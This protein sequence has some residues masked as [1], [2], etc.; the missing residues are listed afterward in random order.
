MNRQQPL[1][2]APP[3]GSANWSERSLLDGLTRRAL[4]SIN[5]AFLDLATDLAEEGRLKLISGLPPRAV[6]ALID[7]DAGQRLCERLPYTLFDLRFGDGGFWESEIAA[8]GGVQ[9]SDPVPATDDRLVA[10]ARAAIM[11]AWHLTQTRAAGARLVFGTSPATIAALATL[12]LATME[13]LARRVAPALT[14]RFGTRTRFWLQFEGCAVRPDEQSVDMLRQLGLQI[15][16]AE[17]ARSQA[18]QRRT[19][20]GIAA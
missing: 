4:C 19:R 10:F 2:L 13:R 20:R 3:A 8:A 11:L 14:A 1:A 16:G 7:P 5:L 15:Q 18:L 12:P 6:D 9:D 17:S